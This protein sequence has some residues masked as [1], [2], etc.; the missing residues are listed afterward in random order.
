MTTAYCPTCRRD[1]EITWS[2]PALVWGNQQLTHVCECG[3][4]F[5]IDGYTNL[6]TRPAR[7]VLGKCGDR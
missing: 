2:L 7:R 3:R 5:T 1:V 4:R 6:V